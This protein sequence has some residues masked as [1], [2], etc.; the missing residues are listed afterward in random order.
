MLFL[1]MISI[2][3]VI[4]VFRLSFCKRHFLS[5]L[6]LLESLMVVTL[7][8]SL[9]VVLLLPN[10]MSSFLLVITFVVCEAAMGVALLLSYIQMNG[11][12]LIGTLI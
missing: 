11:S 6:I 5:M 3:M 7:V 8:F 2:L 4:L 1:K 10:S 12:D 9:S